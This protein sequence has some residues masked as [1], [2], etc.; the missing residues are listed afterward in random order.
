MR[1]LITFR[2]F[3]RDV[4]QA[5]MLSENHSCVCGIGLLNFFITPVRLCVVSSRFCAGRSCRLQTAG[6]TL[7]GG[8]LSCCRLSSC[9]C[10]A[11]WRRR[12][13]PAPAAGAGV[14]LQRAEPTRTLLLIPGQDLGCFFFVFLEVSNAPAIKLQTRHFI[15]FFY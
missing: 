2:A 6:T 7:R 13:R 12:L 8:S 11:G 5:F 4:A 9:S 3:Q 1:G 10:T 14:H 15:T